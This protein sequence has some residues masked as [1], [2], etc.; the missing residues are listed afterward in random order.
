L[1]GVNKPAETCF[2]NKMEPDYLD[3]QENEQKLEQ[4]RA[5]TQTYKRF[6]NPAKDTPPQ[7]DGLDDVFKDLNSLLQKG[8]Q[9]YRY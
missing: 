4:L 3:F 7:S 6:M 5:Q 9:G 1:K 2:E 8:N